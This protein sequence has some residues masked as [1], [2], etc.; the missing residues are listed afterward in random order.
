M[1]LQIF[2]VLNLLIFAIGSWIAKKQEILLVNCFAT[3]PI[4]QIHKKGV[5]CDRICMTT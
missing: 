3:D 4:A 2:V 5:I 1:Q